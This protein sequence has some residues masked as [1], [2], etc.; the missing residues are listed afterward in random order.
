MSTIEDILYAAI[1]LGIK[2]QVFER[3][4]ILRKKHPLKHLEDLY[5]TAFEIEKKKKEDDDKHNS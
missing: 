5:E 4:S 1:K 3:V 2:P